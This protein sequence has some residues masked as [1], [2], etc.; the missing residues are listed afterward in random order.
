MPQTREELDS[1]A[2]VT[3]LCKSE[4]R[5]LTLKQ[6]LAN[7]QFIFLT[8][9]LVMASS[10]IFLPY[11]MAHFVTRDSWITAG[12]LVANAF[13]LYLITWLFVRIC[14]NRTLVGGLLQGFGPWMGRALAVVF[15]GMVFVAMV[16]LQRKSS[17]FIGE[18]LSPATPLIVIDMCIIIP[19]GYAAFL[20]LEVLG[21]LSDVLTPAAALVTLLICALSLR[22]V[23]P[24]YLLPVL[25]NGMDPVLRGAVVP[26]RFTLQSLFCLQFVHALKNPK[27]DLPRNFLWVGLIVAVVGV[28]AHL[29]MVS[30]LGEQLAYVKYPLLEIVKAIRYG[31]F[32]Q[33]LDPV[34]V[35]G[36]LMA[37]MLQQ[38]LMLYIFVSAAAETFNLHDYRN[39]V[40]PAVLVVAA[41][42]LLLWKDGES[43]D[44]FIV[45]THPGIFIT[46]LLTL[47]TMAIVS[48]WIRR[49]GRQT[50]GQ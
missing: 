10:A 46:G 47:P 17:L 31:D 37:L 45:Y 28:V 2:E 23:H 40:W 9:W 39:L 41:C 49:R 48:G 34:Y 32:F 27:K 26:W 44:E 43:V 18:N 3:L 25:A 4:V 36:V 8:S 42:S 35:G 7:V 38:S 13:I 21:R 5:V 1:R 6:Q 16:T 15:L 22:N 11:L 12:L 33:R 14:P 20:G 30:I 50:V 29:L 19:V 24:S